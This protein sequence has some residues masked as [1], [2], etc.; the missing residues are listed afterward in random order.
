[1]FFYRLKNGSLD[2]KTIMTSFLFSPKEKYFLFVFFVF[3]LEEKLNAIIDIDN[4]K[5]LK[6]LVV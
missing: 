6:I 2:E 3:C 1:M 5:Y 4:L